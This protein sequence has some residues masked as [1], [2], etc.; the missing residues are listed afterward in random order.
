MK[1]NNTIK[2]NTASLIEAVQE[3]LD[4]RF[5]PEH[6]VKVTNVNLDRSGQLGD[7]DC[8]ALVHIAEEGTAQVDRLTAGVIKKGDA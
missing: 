5:L 8:P 6:R 7:G 2:F 3:Y 1:G 4:K